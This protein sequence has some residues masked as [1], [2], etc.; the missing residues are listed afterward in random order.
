MKKIIYLQRIGDIDPG[1]LIVLIKD[2]KWFF[3]KYGLKI[4]NLPDPFHLLESEYDSNKRQYDALKVKKRLIKYVKNKGYYRVLG[5]LDVD[6]FSKYLN[7]VFGVADLPKNKSFGSA[8]ISI[9]RLREK[10]YRRIENVALFKLRIVK[11][12]IHELGHTFGLEHC[13]NF[14]VMKFSNDLE[15]T[16]QKPPKFCEDCANRMDII[17]NSFE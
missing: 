9:T 17:I 2:L 14:C 8:L 15:D 6:I 11:E 12:A 3:K 16:D 7:F 1:I 13:T 4:V 10:F 5:V